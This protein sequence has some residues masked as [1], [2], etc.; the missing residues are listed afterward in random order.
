MVSG[1]S[2]DLNSFLS[3]AWAVG[4]WS[5]VRKVTTALARLRASRTWVPI[6]A[7]SIK[8]VC[9][10][11]F[12]HSPECWRNVTISSAHTGLAIDIPYLERGFFS[13]LS[14][15]GGSTRKAQKGGA[16]NPF[17]KKPAGPL[18]F[19]VN[20]LYTSLRLKF[21]DPSEYAFNPATGK[22]MQPL[23]ASEFIKWELEIQQCAM[24]SRL[25]YSASGVLLKALGNGIMR[26]A[27]KSADN[28]I[29]NLEKDYY[30]IKGWDQLFL[31]TTIGKHAFSAEGMA[32]ANMEC[33][34]YFPDCG[35]T[36][37]VYQD[38]SSGQAP[39]GSAAASEGVT[40][41]PINPK[42]TVYVIFK[43]SSSAKDFKSD[44][45]LFKEPLQ[46][47]PQLVGK[48]G[49]D[50]TIHK[51][52]HTHMAKELDEMIKAVLYYKQ[53]LEIINKDQCRLVVCGHSLGGAMAT[54]FSYILC[55]NNITFGKQPIEC[56]TYG[57]PPTFSDKAR[58]AFNGCLKSGQLL[59]NR[60]WATNDGITIIP[61]GMSHGG[62]KPSKLE[63]SSL[64][65]D[66][67]GRSVDINILRNIFCGASF[68][69]ETPDLLS[70]IEEDNDDLAKYPEFKRIINSLLDSPKVL[71]EE[72]S[73]A[74][75]QDEQVGN[76][77]SLAAT[78][79]ASAGAPT[80]TGETVET[81]EIAQVGGMRGGAFGFTSNARLYKTESEKAYPT[82]I[83]YLC[84]KP[85]CHPGYGG[86]GFM[87]AIRIPTPGL[88][89]K[90]PI[91]QTK[92]FKVDSPMIAHRG[93]QIYIKDLQG[94]PISPP[95]PAMGG[96]RKR[97]ATHKKRRHVGRKRSHKR[98][99]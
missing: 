25:A 92:F 72:K 63:G 36:M 95:T 21:K 52:F 17:S 93:S 81:G 96:R 10:E 83:Q 66:N 76:S 67:T 4:L 46:N 98:R 38:T 53:T 11:S 75:I 27:Y 94:K 12:Q 91:Y 8:N 77:A 58:N 33:G 19:V 50:G 14:R 84:T 69:N 40:P 54:L 56:F 32:A 45:T 48:P 49:V 78:T 59:F 44:L 1:T 13:L 16:W 57:A 39:T 43:G 80:V 47:I 74:Q 60:I 82:S 51:G 30:D 71:K 97:K 31:D 22:V 89:K 61:P 6:P 85:G 55:K 65:V 37:V 79:D 41:I 29:T 73:A 86:T 88:R 15:M 70:L 23:P 34:R 20:N 90:E 35:C 24:L 2:R 64:S 5:Q 42:A 99:A 62:Y 28:L 26:N 87:S 3:Q 18:P 68:P 9:I 7:P